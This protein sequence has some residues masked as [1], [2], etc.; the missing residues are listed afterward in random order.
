MAF[1]FKSNKT[2]I[3]FIITS[4]FLSTHYSS[5]KNF[6]HRFVDKLTNFFILLL[7]LL[8]VSSLP[9]QYMLSTQRA[10]TFTVA[11]AFLVRFQSLPRSVTAFTPLLVAAPVTVSTTTTTSPDASPFFLRQS[12]HRYST[13]STTTTALYNNNNNNMAMSSD[14]AT[15]KSTFQLAD[16]ET[17]LKHLQ[18]QQQQ[19]RTIVLDVRTDAEIATDG[20]FQPPGCDYHHVSCSPTDASALV[21]QA[22]QL[23]S[24]HEK[25]TPIIV[26]CKSGRRAGTAKQALM[27]DLGYTNVHNAGGLGDIQDMKL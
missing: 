12:F 27:V 14:Y 9:L 25:D 6:G 18:P 7:P 26:Y 11:A 24:N 10:W 3:Q 20:V 17:L 8:P 22:P 15:R 16:R 13:A 23:F 4:H 5:H 1:F 21:Q 2:S 19:D